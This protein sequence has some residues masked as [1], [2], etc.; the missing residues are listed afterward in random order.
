ML[1]SRLTA[2]A[3]LTGGRVSLTGGRVSLTGTRASL[4]GTRA[5]LTGA[6]QANHQLALSGPASLTC[7]DPTKS[8]DPIHLSASWDEARSVPCG[9][10]K[11]AT[12]RLSCSMQ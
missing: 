10:A 8:L 11:N 4:T 3:S 5:S 9:L 12:T 6:G 1:E 2:D 7:C